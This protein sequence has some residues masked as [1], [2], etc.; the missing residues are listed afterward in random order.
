MRIVYHLGAHFTDE[1][2]LLK[3]LL[4]NREVLAEHGIV[5]PGPK[6]YRNL[7]RD[8]AIQLKGTPASRDTQALILDKIMEEDI[9]NRMVLSWDSFLSLAPWALD[10]TLYPA[11]GERVRAFSQIFPEIEAEFHLAIRNPA[12]FLPALLEKLPNKTYAEF[13]GRANIT[14]LHW[15]QVIQRILKLNP[16]IPLTIWCDEDTPLIWPEVLRAVA[17]LPDDL[18]LE[19]E[20]DLLASLMS[21]EGMTRLHAYLDGHPPG[22]VMQ[23]RKIVSAFLDK[24]ALP[25]RIAT[26]VEMPGWTD[27]TIAELTRLYDEDVYRIANMPGVRFIA[28]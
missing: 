9:A 19:G 26:E 8:T 5:V 24:F 12:T 28:P 2:R 27:T 23:R 11:A 10:G 20:D 25:D 22:S 4:K 15:S 17:G 14:Q 18:V 1:E 21:G 16:G 3:C 7:L 6:R 13:I